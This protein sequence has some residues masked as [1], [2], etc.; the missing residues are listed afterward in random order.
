MC[1]YTT[2]HNY[3]EVGVTIYSVEYSES[4]QVNKIYHSSYYNI[5]ALRVWKHSDILIYFHHSC[6]APHTLCTQ[7]SFYFS[8]IHLIYWT[9]SFMTGC[10]H[11]TDQLNDVWIAIL[12]KQLYTQWRRLKMFIV[13]ALK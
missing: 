3:Y 2:T 1:L 5:L 11:A 12:L 4:Q 10:F 9:I 8:D 7:F 6:P 13:Q